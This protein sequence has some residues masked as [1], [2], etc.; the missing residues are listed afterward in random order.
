MARDSWRVE[1][2]PTDINH[3]FTTESSHKTNA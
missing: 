1:H 3:A 2:A